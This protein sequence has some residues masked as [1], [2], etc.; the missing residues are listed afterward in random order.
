LGVFEVFARVS[1]DIEAKAKIGGWLHA[2][3]VHL[4]SSGLDS[5]HERLLS[6]RFDHYFRF[7]ASSAAGHASALVVVPAL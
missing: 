5:P 4:G 2:F 3:H 1:K 7:L 6:P